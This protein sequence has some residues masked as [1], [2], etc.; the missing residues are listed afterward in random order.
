MPLSSAV[1]IVP[2]SNDRELN[3]FIQF[4]WTVYR[5]NPVWV[6]PIV[7]DEK[8]FLSGKTKF[9][10][11][12]RHRL[13]L[14]REQ[15]RVTATAACFSDSAY[16]RHWNENAGFLG[17]FEALPEK[18]ESVTEILKASE[19]WLREEGI[20]TVY[21]PVNGHIANPAGM[22][23]NAYNESPVCLMS[24]NPSYYH[25]Y[26]KQGGY[27]PFKEL[28]ALEMDLLDGA[29]KRKVGFIM[30][31]AAQ[32]QVRVR[33][34]D[35]TRFEEDSRNLARIYSYTFDRHW[36]F[37]PLSEDE[38]CEILFSLK[39]VIDYDLMLFAEAEGKTVGFVFGLP[40]YNPIVKKLD[41]NITVFSLPVFFRMKKQLRGARI[42][43]WG[44]LAE[45]R[46]R[47]VVPVLATCAYNAL[48][49]KG[50]TVCENS[51]ILKEN[52]SSQ[53]TAH[54]FHS[55]VYKNYMVYKKDL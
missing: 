50:Y 4:R 32:S 42:L 7:Q 25:A 39:A 49:K 34:F 54:K 12:C 21:G 33:R 51:W 3:E 9:F 17:Y 30:K 18:K 47:N 27:N 45:W 31:K 5:D 43:A 36:G 15:G 23:M 14:A 38:I 24:Y 53:K 2:V 10:T 13:F 48:I 11:H 28:L 8:K 55:R 6:P 1:Q 41:G 35:K 37:S 22:L 52:V 16:K 40:D 20:E 26:F 44:A 46:G 19:S 29:L